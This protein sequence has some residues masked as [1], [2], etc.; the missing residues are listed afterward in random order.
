VSKAHAPSF[1]PDLMRDG[2]V[3]RSAAQKQILSDDIA[4]LLI[5]V[6]N[7]PSW[8]SPLPYSARQVQVVTCMAH[9]EQHTDGAR[10]KV[11]WTRL[12]EQLVHES[13]LFFT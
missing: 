7:V 2:F 3:A 11:S 1:L 4:Q 8:C 12:L 5:S 6:P 9:F 13:S 10:V